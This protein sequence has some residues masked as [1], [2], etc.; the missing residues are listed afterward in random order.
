MSIRWF[1]TREKHCGAEISW[2]FRRMKKWNLAVKSSK[3]R[4]AINYR[5][6]M[7]T[8]IMRTRKWH[9]GSLWTWWR[10]RTPEIQ[11]YHNQNTSVKMG[12]W[13]IWIGCPTM[14]WITSHL[15]FL[16]RRLLDNWTRNCSSCQTGTA[17]PS[18][19]LT[20]P[21]SGS[22]A[23]SR[24]WKI[25]SRSSLSTGSLIRGSWLRKT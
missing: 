11:D 17:C 23:Q 10:H 16:N 3:L 1:S 2:K 18:P 13:K 15:A 22:K 19:N 24:T 9:H 12:L 14:T 7:A 8:V 6:L 5:H 25:L 4:S 21:Y 20:M